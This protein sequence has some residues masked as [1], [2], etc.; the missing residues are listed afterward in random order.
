MSTQAAASVKAGAKAGAA[1]GGS[2]FQA[3]V[4]AGGPGSGLYPLTQASPKVLLP[5]ANQPMLYYQLMALEKAGFAEVIV[6]VTKDQEEDIGAYLSQFY[7]GQIRVDLVGL[8]EPDGEAPEAEAGTAEVL[9][10]LREKI[11]KDIFVVSGDVVTMASLQD[12]ADVHRTSDAAV[13]MLLKQHPDAQLKEERSKLRKM[14]KQVI[15]YFGV[16]PGN[17]VGTKGQTSG[18]VVLMKSAAQEDPVSV[19]KQLLRREPRVRLHSDLF[20]AH[21][22]IMRR[23]VVELL[24]SESDD[25]ASRRARSMA[26][27]RTDFLPFVVNQLQP[28]AAN[29]EVCKLMNRLVPSCN[30]DDMDED[31]VMDDELTLGQSASQRS[32][33]KI[34]C[35]AL[36]LPSNSLTYRAN[37]L[38]SYAATNHALANLPRGAPTPWPRPRAAK[39]KETIVGESTEIADTASIRNCV[40][41]SHCKIGPDVEIS[42][43]IIMDHCTIEANA[44]IQHSILGEQSFV[45]E[46]CSLTDIQLEH[47]CSISP[48]GLVLKSQAYLKTDFSS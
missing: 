18:R 22:Y 29:P 33:Q 7:P 15:N 3:V 14:T 28:N 44:S 26:T 20:D 23:W 30:S 5:L 1:F 46:G 45:P 13:T 10:K 34:T 31:D 6:A 47:G 2:E 21:V 32:A 40:I 42:N 25:L 36:I 12:M 24:C 17:T 19:S 41:G 37:T 16:V 35:Q 39:Y 43:T 9:R 8:S 48:P 38:Y 11:T 27:I 4:L